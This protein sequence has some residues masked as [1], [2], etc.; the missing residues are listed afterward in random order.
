[1]KRTVSETLFSLTKDG[2]DII[3]S[4]SSFKDPLVI[5]IEMT[6]GNRCIRHLITYDE[7]SM[8]IDPDVALITKIENMADEFKEK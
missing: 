8:R 2:F 5:S 7:M 4:E 1:M 3:I 6:K